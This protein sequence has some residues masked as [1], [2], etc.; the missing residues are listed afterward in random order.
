M[1]AIAFFVLQASILLLVLLGGGL[2]PE[3]ICIV[4]ALT[5]AVWGLSLVRRKSTGT[6]LDSA[7]PAF[8]WLEVAMAAILVFILLTVL[9]LHPFLEALNGALRRQQ[10]QTVEV[11]LRQAA[12]LGLLDTT[13]PWFAL[14]RNRGG[15]LRFLLL[16]SAAFGAMMA[17]ASLPRRWRIA[18]LHFIAFAGAVVAAGG[19]V[20]Q[21]VIPEGDT[22]WWT[23]PIPHVLPG[24][25]G[26]FVNRNHFAGFVAMLAPVAI[27]LT[28][29]AIRRRALALAVLLLFADV[30]LLYALVMSL[31]RGALLAFLATSMTMLAWGLLRR[32]FK[33]AL[34]YLAMLGLFAAAVYSASPAL[35]ERLQTLHDPLRTPSV[36]NRLMEWRESL[37]V[38]P[39]YPCVGAGANALRMV[40]PQV[41]RTASGGWLL[42]AENEY[43]QLLAEGGAVGVALAGALLWAGRRRTREAADPVP[44]AMLLSVT[45]AALVAAIHCTFDFPFHLPLYAVTLASLLGLLLPSPSP[46]L[47]PQR[48]VLQL[49]PVFI[50]L[51]ASAIIALSSAARSRDA[52]S[53][54]YLSQAPPT[55]LRRALVWAP[56]SW[57]AWYFLGRAACAEGVAERRV[58]LCFFGEDLMTQAARY[59]PN[60]YRLWYELGRTRRALGEYGRARAAFERAHELRP[61]MEV[62]A[63]ERNP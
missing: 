57:H 53:F 7:Q 3:T 17:S 5:C 52:D 33:A 25:V 41:R 51:T 61:W 2:F 39:S 23:I 54:E 27:I 59:D 43:I 49:A 55:E 9:P 63:M 36:E 21:W 35:R 32:S 12:Q 45:G 8:P 4:S 1:A 31:S 58:S 50:G 24:P 18:Y 30:A 60:N 11:A 40:Y 48:R 29:R 16:I 46:A 14:S 22:L 47:A 44:G 20:S 34:V 37:R 42:F 15:T 26:C 62:P 28:D 19:Y 56:T 13:Q 10:N 6:T 38:F